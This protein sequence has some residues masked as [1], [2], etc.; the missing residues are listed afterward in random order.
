MGEYKVA[1]D[2]IGTNIE[3]LRAFADLRCR[4]GAG[5]GAGAGFRSGNGRF[6]MWHP[7]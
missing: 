3:N 2:G 4:S 6:S 5:A 1:V 7:R